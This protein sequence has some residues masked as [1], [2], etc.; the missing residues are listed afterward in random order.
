MSGSYYAVRP[1]IKFMPKNAGTAEISASFANV[2][3]DGD[4]L[5][6]QADGFA[7]NYNCRIQSII[8][9]KANDKL[10]FNGFIRG[11]KNKN[12]AENWRFSASLNA[13]IT[14]K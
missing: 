6:N 14:I 12:T 8:G 5:Y 13:E 1:G 9:I 2:N 11:D 4:L 3:F 10:R 7:K